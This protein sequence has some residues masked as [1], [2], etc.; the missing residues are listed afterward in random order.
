[1]EK[2]QNG[3]GFG[4]LLGGIGAGIF[5]IMVIFLAFKYFNVNSL[6]EVLYPGSSQPSQSAKQNTSDIDPAII[7]AKVGAENIYQIDLDM[8]IS[9][10]PMQINEDIKKLLLQK[11]VKDSIILQAA[12]AE[13]LIDLD[14]SVFNSL[15]KDYIK[16]TKLVADARTIYENN[17]NSISGSVISIWFYNMQPGAVGYDKGKEIAFNKITT[18]HSN[19]KS[20]KI[21]IQQAAQVIIDDKSLAQVDESYDS[22]A[23]L[24]F[25]AEPKDEIT[26]DPVFDSLI[27]QLA[28]GQI[29]NIYLAKD[30]N[31]DTDKMIDAVY[32][33]AQV[34]ERNT[35]GKTIDFDMWYGQKEKSYEIVYY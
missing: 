12:N 29:S 35:T 22:N 10:Y 6:Q 4:M 2:Q 13:K 33:F 27:R 18:L 16:R 11:V 23:I 14:E 20:K 17:Q 15:Q 25:K 26:F 5:I 1:M 19:L 21:T 31:R 24:T 28:Q 9:G 3:I 7:I 30:K 8:E 34:N 32:M